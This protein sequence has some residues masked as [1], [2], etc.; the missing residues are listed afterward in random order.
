[1]ASKIGEVLEIESVD[2]YMK[3]PVGPMITVEIQNI[4]K[5]VGFIHIPSMAERTTPKDTTLQNILYSGLPNQ[6]RKRH[7]FGHFA[8]ACTVSKAPIWD[9][10]AP[11][12]KLPT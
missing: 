2:L 11:V 9:E 8:R 3:I 4:S 1:M 5:L 7:H 12:G 6:C 10:S